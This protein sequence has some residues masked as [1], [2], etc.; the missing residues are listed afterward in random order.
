MAAAA[1]AFAG[2]EVMVHQASGIRDQA[3]VSVAQFFED[4][5]GEA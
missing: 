4:R 2:R 3:S 5:Q 1:A